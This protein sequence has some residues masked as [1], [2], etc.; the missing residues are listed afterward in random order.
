LRA[1]TARFAQ[2]APPGG[3]AGGDLTGTYPNPII[4]TGVVSATKLAD[5]SVT[6]AKILDGTVQRVDVETTFK[7]PY[8][9]T[10]DYAK[11]SL[12]TGSAGGDLAGTYPNPTL[13]TTG[14]SA[15]PYTNA[16]ITVDGK[17]RITSASSGIAGTVS[18]VG[19]SMPGQFAVSGS[20]VTTSGTLTA[21]WN[22]QTANTVLAGPSSGTGAPAFRALVSA[23]IPSFD[24][25]KIT[26]G[27]LPVARGG[28]NSGAALNS[29]RI[30]ISFGGAIM[31]AG[32][33]TNGQLLI[34]STGGTPVGATLTSGS[35]INI[36]NGAGS[37]AIATS[38]GTLSGGTTNYIPKWTSSTSL[39]STSI[40]YDN[41]TNVGIGTTSP[42]SK[43][44][45]KGSSDATQLIVQ[46]NSTQSN[47][48][49][50]I[51]L[52]NSSGTDLLSIHS[53][54]TN[55]VFL[56]LN[57]GRV[58]NTG[59]G[60]IANTFIGAYAAYS[61]TGGGYNTA[62]GQ[63][64]LYSNTTGSGNTA[65]GQNALYS[66]STGF[67]NTADGRDAL[68]SN[69]T[70]YYNTAS[71]KWSL[72]EITTQND[73]VA[74]G[75][76][77]GD[78]YAFLQGTFVGSNCY[79]NSNGYTN[80]SGLGYAA[81]PTASNSVRIGNA[82]VTSIGGYANWTNVSDARFK[83]NVRENVKGLEFVMK[84][85]PVTYNLDAWKLAETLQEDRR[86]DKDGNITTTQPDEA[87]A[88]ARDD[89]SA[90][91]QTGLIAQEVERAAR[92]VGYDF[93][94]VDAPKNEN[95]FYGLRYAEFVAPLV[96]A[97]QEQQKM[98]EELQKR[99]EELEKRR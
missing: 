66:N 85:H 3:T 44:H 90:I 60:A 53:D 76:S 33:L 65:N 35:G 38:G 2:A 43:L 74:L 82:S 70:G 23:D 64:A 41:G 49:P 20:P 42:S 73:N 6:S 27:V 77:A 79:P 98:I 37:I 72:Y 13:T 12:P 91:V 46:A 32:A 8:S 59:G 10:A 93:S 94:G 86:R 16:N 62:N 47:N 9:D 51:K 4:A 84:L 67:D 15:G 63:N 34:G 30:M 48:N 55:N 78:Y 14:V 99:I 45:V 88:K 26:S 50:L 71:G 28:T 95:D 24:A 83:K 69:T 54:N 68:Y 1:D 21:N 39:S 7:A 75:Y 80:V 40:L 29:N 31:E 97:V 18:S 36:T 56:G 52:R 25:S 22:S 57:A 11:G 89:K 61:N 92:E 96:K 58:N 87:T 19:L 5:G 17:G 81:S